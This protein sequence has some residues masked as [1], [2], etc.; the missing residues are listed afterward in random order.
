MSSDSQSDAGGDSTLLT[1]EKGTGAGG[2]TLGKKEELQ[3]NSHLEELIAS[4]AEKALVLRWLHDQAEK[5][6]SQ[7][8]TNISFPVIIISTLAGTASIGQDTLF[9]GSASAPVVIG[10]MSLLVSTLN[11]VSNFFGWAKRAEGHR[12][13]GINYAKLHRWISIE[14]A[15]PRDQRIPAK[16]FLKQIREQIDRLNETSPPVPQTIIDA[17]RVKVKNLK[18]DVSVPEICNEIHNVDVYRGKNVEE[19]PCAITIRNPMIPPPATVT[20]PI[21]LAI[22]P[23]HTHTTN[24]DGP[25]PQLIAAALATL[26]KSKQPP[27][28]SSTG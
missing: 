27:P 19:E 22:N 10:L 6:Y 9:G 26:A 8:N 3:Y 21:Q 18:G 17:F 11:V 16:H 24:E 2:N 13:S 1:P 7:F 28:S 23:M 25:S 14:L 4:E 20:N 5:R 15:L 12:I